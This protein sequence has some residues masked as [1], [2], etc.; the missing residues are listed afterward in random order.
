VTGTGHAGAGR[1]KQLV[2]Q[3]ASVSTGSA[4]TSALHDTAMIGRSLDSDMKSLHEKRK[5]VS[6]FVRPV[7]LGRVNETL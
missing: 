1:E 4:S 3:Q 7:G 5:E 6:I 2:N